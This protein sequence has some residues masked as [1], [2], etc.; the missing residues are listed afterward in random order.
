MNYIFNFESEDFFLRN[1]FFKPLYLL[2]QVRF[3]Y[4][5]NRSSLKNKRILDLGCGLGMLSEKL[6]LH[7]GIVTA[8]D[9]SESL[10]KLAI[11]NAVCK[12]INIDY[13]CFDF[14]F[15]KKI[16]FLFDIIICTEVLEHVFDKIELLKYLKKISKSDTLIF[17]SSLDKNLFSY[18]EIIFL[19]EFSSLILPKNTHKF[20]YF[21]TLSNL[22]T[23]LNKFGFRISD[24]KY[25]DYKVFLGYSNLSLNGCV[26]Y[27]LEIVKEK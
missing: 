7:G 17:I 24:I 21:I 27:L 2:N 4:I 19:G 14:F 23:N 16:D 10:I 3:D 15:E 18:F 20:E 9:K 13:I 8:V 26:N 11:K 5:F 12:K 22:N 1:N 6:A 25:L